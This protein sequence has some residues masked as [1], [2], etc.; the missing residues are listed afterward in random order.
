[1]NNAEQNDHISEQEYLQGELVSEIKHE[2]VD[3]YVYAM[4]GASRN[5]ERIVQNIARFV[6]QHLADSSSCEP[7]GSDTKVKTSTGKYRYPDYMVVCDET[8]DDEYYTESP[9]ILVEVLS[10]TT[11]QSDYQAKRLEYINIPTLEEYVLIE[12]DFVGI[13]VFRKTAHWQPDYYFLGE[14]VTFES[15]DLTLPVADIYH[16]V[17][18]LDMV[19]WLESLKITAD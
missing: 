14:E 7:L 9:V 18:N 15:I 19:Q 16:R 1:M 13:T 12:Q 11:R 2:Y 3:G 4:A 17:D 6:G 8:I 10:H 5:H